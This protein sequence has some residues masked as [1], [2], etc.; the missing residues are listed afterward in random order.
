M[1]TIMETDSVL[2]KDDAIHFLLCRSLM[3]LEATSVKATLNKP[4]NFGLISM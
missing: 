1:E 4:P 2:M 3:H